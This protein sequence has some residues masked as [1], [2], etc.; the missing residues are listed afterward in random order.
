ML[1]PLLLVIV[2]ESLEAIEMHGVLNCLLFE[3]GVIVAFPW[4]VR[5][6]LFNEFRRWMHPSDF[7][8]IV[9]KVIT[10][11]RNDFARILRRISTIDYLSHFNLTSSYDGRHLFSPFCMVGP[12]RLERTVAG[13]KIRC[14]AS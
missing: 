3:N 5:I 11:D 2:N 9:G 13:L 10:Y 1:R 14:F 12:V 7:A 4:I 8:N 6:R